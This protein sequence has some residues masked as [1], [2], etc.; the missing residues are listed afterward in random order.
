MKS[1]LLVFLLFNFQANSQLTNGQVYNFAVGDV[2]QVKSTST[3]GGPPGYLCTLDSIVGKILGNDSITYTIHRKKMYAGPPPLPNYV[4]STE[5]MVVTN[6]NVPAAH[7][8]TSTCSPNITY[9]DTA[10]TGSCGA[11]VNFRTGGQDSCFEPVLWHSILIEGLG[12]PYDMVYDPS[13]PFGYQNELIYSNTA[14][15]GECGT[16]QDMTL[17]LD[18]MTLPQPELIKIVDILGNQSEDVPNKLLIYLYSDGTT[19]KVFQVE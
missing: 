14:Q 1:L 5:T 16:Y 2:L 18:E 11:W 17:G 13:G 15:W 12:G 10:Y 8:V 19:K 3:V 9:S 7:F 4:L 6:L